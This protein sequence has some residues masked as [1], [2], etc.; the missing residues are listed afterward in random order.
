MEFTIC[1]ACT[2][3]GAEFV[4]CCSWPLNQLFCLEDLTKH[5]AVPS[6]TFPHRPMPI[7]SLETIKSKGQFHDLVRHYQGLDRLKGKFA[8]M[9]SE[10]AKLSNK[11]DEAFDQAIIR[12]QELRTV[13]KSQLDLECRNWN[14]KMQIS[15]ME[16][17]KKI[18]EPNYVV[19]GALANHCWNFIY[20]GGTT[21]LLPELILLKKE[22]KL[23]IRYFDDKHNALIAN[24][25]A[26]LTNNSIAKISVKALTQKYVGSI[27][28]LNEQIRFTTLCCCLPLCLCWP[29][30]G[31][32][33]AV[34]FSNLDDGCCS[35]IPASFRC[36]LPTCLCCVGAAL[37]RRFLMKWA[38]V[39]TTSFLEE[40]SLYSMHIWNA[41]LVC[42]EAEVVRLRE[43]WKL[44]PELKSKR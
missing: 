10:T 13:Y 37:N 26:R 39:K 43:R 25:Q 27:A 29:L 9:I 34:N 12:I 16:V 2:I 22:R 24:C 40:L 30:V 6:S 38:G 15:L 33:Q 35:I 44:F 5:I 28:N 19:Q 20:M 21:E 1:S 14:D 4:C 18:A 3:R 41:C 11:L 32:W 36:L 42:Q 23:F 31:L 17:D 7:S 8:E